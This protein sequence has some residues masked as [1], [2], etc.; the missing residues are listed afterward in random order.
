MIMGYNV[1]VKQDKEFINLNEPDIIKD[2]N[3]RERRFIE[4]G[5]EKSVFTRI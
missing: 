5:K 2:R 4:Y 3:C 1:H